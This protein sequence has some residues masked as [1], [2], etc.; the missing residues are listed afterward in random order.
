MGKHAT[1]SDDGALLTAVGRR[2]IA[3]LKELFDRHATDV[4]RVALR[5]NFSK[6]DAERVVGEVFVSVWERPGDFNHA[7]SF[8]YL[9]RSAARSQCVDQSQ[10]NMADGS[11]A[12]G[13]GSTLGRLTAS[14]TNSDER[15]ALLAV[16]V[17]GRSLEDVGHTRSGNASRMA[18][19]VRRAL[20]HVHAVHSAVTSPTETFS[21]AS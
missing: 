1:T 21:A 2:E 13:D 4:Y 19:T 18:Q 10:P 17:H 12:K 16:A 5:M 9:A 15:D 6:I 8:G 11:R 20:Q 14:L 7:C 3:A